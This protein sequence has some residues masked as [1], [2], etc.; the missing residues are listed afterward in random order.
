VQMASYVC[1]T[2]SIYSH[3]SSLQSAAL[4]EHQANVG[5]KRL[6]LITL[7]V[8]AVVAGGRLSLRGSSIPTRITRLAAPAAA[9]STNIT[10]D[11]SSSSSLAGWSVG[12]QILVTSTTFNPDQVEFRHIAAVQPAAD[13]S[14]LVLV[15]DRPLSWNHGGG[16]YR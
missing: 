11:G 2:P 10:V 14:Q 6:S 13:S 4:H 5:L 9:N 3:I 12:K 7:Q 1:Q 15:L 8:L 16:V